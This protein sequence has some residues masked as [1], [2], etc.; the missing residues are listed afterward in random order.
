MLV[1]LEGVDSDDSTDVIDKI[2]SD[3]QDIK[4]G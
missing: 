2:E 4:S 1:C 3:L